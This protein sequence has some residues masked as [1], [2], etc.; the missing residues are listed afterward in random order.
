MV[1][2]YADNVIAQQISQITGVAQVHH[3]RRAEARGARPGR[4]G[5]AADPRPDARGRA[6]RARHRHHQRRQGHAS[7]APSRASPSQPTTSSPRPSEYN[8]VIIAYRNGAP[9]RVRDVGHAV[10]GPQDVNIAALMAT[11]SRR[12][13]LLV[14]KQ[15]GANV[16]ETVDQ[17]KAA[18]PRL[19]RLIPPGMKLDTIVDRTQTIRASVDDVEFTLALTIALVVLVIL[20]FLRNLRA[21]LIPA[22]RGAAVAARRHRADVSARLQ[23]R[24]SLADGDDHRGRLRG[25]RRHRRGREHLPPHRGR[26]AADAGRAQGRARD[27][28]HGRLDQHLAGRGVHS[29]AADGRHRRPAVPRIRAS[30]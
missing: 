6:Q 8:D 28:L 20:L 12:V 23:P 9:V 3:R 29:A 25:R 15:P 30:R 14:F 27:R 16:I 21:T 13:I 24:Q 5:Q 17:I 2:D 18:M 22:R 7:T 11:T 4:S 19:S 1:D 26:H 10:A